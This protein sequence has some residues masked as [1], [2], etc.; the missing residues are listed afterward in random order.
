MKIKEVHAP[1][2]GT[3]ETLCGLLITKDTK[4]GIP[5]CKTCILERSRM[6]SKKGGTGTIWGSRYQMADEVSTFEI[7]T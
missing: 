5:T 4:V 3:W 7:P 6:G 2:M 1:R